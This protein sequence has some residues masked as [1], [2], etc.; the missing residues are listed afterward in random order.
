MI[1]IKE[2]VCLHYQYYT[3]N[4]CVAEL[5]QERLF[6]QDT[7]NKYNIFT[8]ISDD[9]RW[10]STTLFKESMQSN[11]ILSRDLIRSYTNKM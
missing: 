10:D 7:Y 6:I 3:K 9:L 8:E 2:H 4:V 1:L 5:D 11:F